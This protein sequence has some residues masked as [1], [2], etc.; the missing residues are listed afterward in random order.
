M[1]QPE[2]Q[3]PMPPSILSNGNVIPLAEMVDEEGGDE[4]DEDLVDTAAAHTVCDRDTIGERAAG[5]FE[6]S[7]T[8][9]MAW[10]TRFS[11]M[12]NVCILEREGVSFLRFAKSCQ[13]RERR[14]NLTRGSTPA[15]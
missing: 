5:T 13:G 15:T 9:L 3:N 8:L 4:E 10:S 7:E 11:S 12:I 2:S 6:R 1:L 14:L